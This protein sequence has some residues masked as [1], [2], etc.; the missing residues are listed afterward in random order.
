MSG[1]RILRCL[2]A[3]MLL[4]VGCFVAL[5]LRFSAELRSSSDEWVETAE[6]RRLHRQFVER[7]VRN[8]ARDDA[9]RRR[10]LLAAHEAA[11]AVSR[12]EY[13]R[14]MGEVR[15]RAVAAS[16]GSA[17][18]AGREAAASIPVDERHSAYP[19]APKSDARYSRDRV[20]C[21][22]PYVWDRGSYDAI[23][24]TWGKRCNVINFI[25]DPTVLDPDDERYKDHAE[26]PEG[27]FP[28]NVH[29]VNVTRPWSGCIDRKGE[30]MTFCRHIWEKV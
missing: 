13:E 6:E 4:A 17:A 22:V 16:E 1:R 10:A 21:M 20:Y 14:V 11:D 28:D 24:S 23:M 9:G 5:S 12:E 26:F 29:F 18:A 7:T 27:T 15:R 19:S 8:I 2:L 30:E 25:T 3:L